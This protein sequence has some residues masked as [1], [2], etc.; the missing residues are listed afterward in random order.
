MLLPER[1]PKM[2]PLNGG[3]LQ[4]PSAIFV[5]ANTMNTVNKTIANECFAYIFT[6]CTFQP[7]F[8]GENENNRNN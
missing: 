3:F 5:M 6:I 7:F 1:L 4:A 2:L 8:W